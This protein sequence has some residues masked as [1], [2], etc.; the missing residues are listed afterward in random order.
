MN[1]Q[2]SPGDTQLKESVGKRFLRVLRASVVLLFLSNFNTETRR[3][4]SLHGEIR[5]PRQ[6]A[7]GGFEIGF[8]VALKALTS[9]INGAQELKYDSTNPGVTPGLLKK[10]DRSSCISE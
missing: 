5:F 4:R 8:S 3:S 9:P 2:W 6:T 10:E 7:S 1:R